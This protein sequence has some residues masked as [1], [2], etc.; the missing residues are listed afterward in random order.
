MNKKTRLYLGAAATVATAVGLAASPSF[1]ADL[2]VQTKQG[3]LE[4]Q[5]SKSA[6]SF[7]GIHYGA[8]TGGQNRFLPPQPVQRL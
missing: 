6:D 7:L 5:T 1:G 4:G 3:K 2:I 8:D